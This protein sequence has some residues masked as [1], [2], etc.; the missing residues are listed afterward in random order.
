MVKKMKMNTKKISKYLSYI[1]RHKPHTI[2]LTLDN[3][4]WADINELIEKTTSIRL[5]PDLIKTVVETNDKQRFSISDDEKRIRAN[6]GHSIDVDLALEPIRPPDILLHG[7]ATRFLD[8]ILTEGLLKRN[9]HH[10][11]LSE[12]VDAAHAVGRRHGK[13]VILEISA[14]KMHEDGFQFYRSKNGVWLVDHVPPSYIE[15][16]ET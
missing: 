12:T 4:G 13:P 11:H 10:V 1:L 2:D 9:R 8:A 3:E 6:Q 14:V 16:T 7:T 5:S 15:L